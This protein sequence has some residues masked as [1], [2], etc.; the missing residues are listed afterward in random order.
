MEVNMELSIVNLIYDIQNDTQPLS[1]HKNLEKQTAKTQ[2]VAKQ[3][4]GLLPENIVLSEIRHLR[5]QM[6]QV[7]FHL[8][9]KTEREKFH[10]QKKLPKDEKARLMNLETAVCDLV[11]SLDHQLLPYLERINTHKK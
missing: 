8:N 7:L 10:S 9:S 6:Q 4:G 2:S 3:T 5:R 11:S 1:Y